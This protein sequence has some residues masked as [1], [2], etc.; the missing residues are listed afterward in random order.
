MSGLAT[1]LAVLLVACSA[2]QPPTPPEPTS[3]C[4]LLDIPDAT[5][6]AGGRC[7]LAATAMAAR[8]LEFPVTV[9]DL[10]HSVPVYTDGADFFDVQNALAD[11]GLVA[12]VF[13]GDVDTIT[14]IIAAGLPAI[15]AV[16]R[17]DQ[18][19]V[20]LAHGYEGRLGD[21]GGC[22][23]VAQINA[24]D[25]ITGRSS[26]YPAAALTESQHS[27]QLMVVFQPDAGWEERL[28]AAGVDM[29][30]VFAQNRRFRAE[31]WVLRAAEYE[32]HNEYSVRLLRRAISED[33]CWA[34][35]YELLGEAIE[36]IGEER[37]A[38]DRRPEWCDH[39]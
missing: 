8:W 6:Q 33:P 24:I 27:E 35:V 31:G 34:E 32:E 5:P 38:E 23:A 18:K 16:R 39:E 4:V 37:G 22:G 15:V 20:L 26:E 13:Q 2:P 36:V 14:R 3:C 19:H 21:L 30:L 17:G 1:T 9:V 10:V 12:L 7:L 11:L 29:G 28:A 25:P